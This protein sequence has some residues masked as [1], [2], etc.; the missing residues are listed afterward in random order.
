[1]LLRG[2][3]PHGTPDDSLS[4]PLGARL[5]GWWVFIVPDRF[6]GTG[7]HGPAPADGPAL[8]TARAVSAT[9]P[10]KRPA[11][12]RMKGASGRARAAA[13]PDTR[14]RLRRSLAHGG[15]VGR[16]QRGNER[17]ERWTVVLPRVELPQR[18]AREDFRR[19]WP[20]GSASRGPGSVATRPARSAG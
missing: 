4:V 10:G 18:P 3:W 17:P 19:E 16:W 9:A 12:R 20:G 5:T 8:L 11:G 2:G 14:K 7:N 15:S 1:V 6:Q 13:P